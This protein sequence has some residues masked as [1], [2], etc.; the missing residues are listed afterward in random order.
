MTPSQTDPRG[1][2]LLT[3]SPSL[4]RAEQTLDPCRQAVECRL[5]LLLMPC[6]AVSPRQIFVLTS[7]RAL[8]LHSAGFAPLLPFPL[9]VTHFHR[10]RF[11]N[12][13]FPGV[14]RQ[15]SPGLSP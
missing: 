10:I 15:L 6:L 3:P 2:A 1:L 12:F 8:V 5:S 13:Y 11:A 9:S 7:T 14:C 4:A